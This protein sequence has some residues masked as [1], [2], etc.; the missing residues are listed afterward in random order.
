M[1]EGSAGITW[2]AE[3]AVERPALN[4]EMTTAKYDEYALTRINALHNK[5]MKMRV[6]RS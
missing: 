4:H 2:A 3:Y 6:A 5:A 1:I